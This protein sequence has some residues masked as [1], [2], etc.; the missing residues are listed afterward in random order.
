MLGTLL[1]LFGVL[2]VSFAEQGCKIALDSL[3]G[4]YPP[5]LLQ[6]SEFILPKSENAEGKRFLD[7]DGGANIQLYCHGSVR[8]QD[9]TILQ[10]TNLPSAS[11]V[12][13]TCKDGDF[14][15]ADNKKV[16]VEKATC[17]RRQEPRL[18]KT[19]EECSSIGGD[20]R[21]SD[22]ADL[23][24]VQIGFMI[25]DKFIEQI[26]LCQDEKVYAT[27]WTNHTVHGQSIDFRDI[28]DSRPSFRIDNTYLKR[29]FTWTTSTSMN[30]YYSKKTQATTI[31]K[32]LG[33][34]EINGKPVIETSSRGT[35]YFAKG[36]LSP[37]AGFI[38]NINQDATYYYFN[39]APQFQSF[40][41]GNWKALEINTRD[42]ASSLGKD[43]SIWTGTHGVLSYA[44]KYGE[45][46][47]IY[48]YLKDQT[49]YVPAPLYY[50]KVVYDPTT[51]TGAAFIGLNDPHATE[52]PTELCDNVCSSMSWVDWSI[53]ELDA[54]YMYC[55]S[56]E[57]ARKAIPSIPD[58]QTTGLIQKGGSV[59]T[60]TMVDGPCSCTCY[61]G[62]G[63]CGGCSCSCSA[64]GK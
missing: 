42:L 27:I 1:F 52:P 60:Y 39:V 44:D 62:D 59:Y 28:D 55:C 38:Y 46:T 41:N 18:L 2:E 31:K 10:G 7:I 61:Q 23:F 6:N 29:F 4:K 34:N 36:H 24:T 54:G 64:A 3:T 12:E 9:S 51:Q 32:L 48:L 35:N 40:N 13:L 53:T 63:Q 11:S 16:S 15:T 37:D 33:H 43:V 30:S 19:Q 14:V 57:S 45:M 49:R 20:G 22:F 47:D 8:Y 17:S 50:W 56:I 58:L 25:G 26:R 21:T 5:L